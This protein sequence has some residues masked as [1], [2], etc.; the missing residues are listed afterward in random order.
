MSARDKISN[1]S[2]AATATASLPPSSKAHASRTPRNAPQPPPFAD[3][4]FERLIAFF[5]SLRLTVACLAF[6]LLLV[7]I[8]TLAQVEIGLY[9]AQNEF[10]R[11]FFVFWGPAGGS[12]KIP[13]F[14]GGYLLGGVL[15]LNLITSLCTR[16]SFNRK[17]SGIILVHIGLILLLLGQ[18]LTDMLSVESGMQLYE[19][20]TKNYS[21]D[22]RASEL[23]VIDKTDPQFDT[24][25]SIPE[26]KL[27]G[28]G[29]IRDHR[30]PFTVR[31]RKFWPNAV[32]VQ[33][34][35]NAPAGAIASGATAG[36]L[37]DALLMP[38]PVVASMEQRN[39]PG[40]VVELGAGKGSAGSFLVGYSIARENLT[41]I[42]QDVTLDGRHYEVGLRF[43][44]YY[45][46][47]NLTLLKATH[48]QY[49]G[50]DIPKNFASR[51]RVQNPDR[52]EARETAIYMNNPLRYGGLT[53]YQYQMMAGEAAEK[54][55]LPPSSTFQVVRNPSWLTPYLSCILVALGLFVQFGS[56][57]F[58]FVKRRTA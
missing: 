16:F 54:A 41:T 18:L 3:R 22:F 6:G 12:W 31:V 35:A 28:T 55:G 46:P 11:S 27:T 52:N 34:G 14:P 39:T 45:Y 4:F 13:V 56:H 58:D 2:G 15:L 33:P 42:S 20:Q 10:F 38:Q 49:R 23:V 9:K 5:T 53:F 50:T 25:Y 21:E 48:E 7:F 47:F 44:R 17:K 57:L 43:R 37:K 19:G 40:A 8:G 1:P 36:Q 30:L 32:V 29:E 24:V 51:V 26:H